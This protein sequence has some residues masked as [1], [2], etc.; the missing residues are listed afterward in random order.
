M[1]TDDKKYRCKKLDAPL[2]FLEPVGPLTKQY[3]ITFSYI[4]DLFLLSRKNKK[5]SSPNIGNTNANRKYTFC[6]H[7]Q[8]LPDCTLYICLWHSS[9]QLLSE[10]NKIGNQKILLCLIFVTL[11]SLIWD[12]WQQEG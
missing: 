3:P 9:E 7:H 2:L 12:T 4:N 11:V 8:C 1:A 6:Y 5:L 10:N